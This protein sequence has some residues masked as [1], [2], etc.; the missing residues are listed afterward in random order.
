VSWRPEHS[1]LLEGSQD[2]HAGDETA[3][4]RGSEV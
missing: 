3:N 4:I 2:V 1:F